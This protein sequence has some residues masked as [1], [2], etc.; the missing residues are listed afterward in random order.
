MG[1]CCK[2]CPCEACQTVDFEVFDEEGDS[3]A[4]LQKKSRGCCKSLTTTADNFFV[5]FP[6]NN[7]GKR[8]ALLMASLIFLDYMFFE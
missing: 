6:K 7:N 2:K 4:K 3:I 8:R 1:L 5:E